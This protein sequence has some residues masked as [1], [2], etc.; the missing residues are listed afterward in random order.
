MNNVEQQF[1]HILKQLLSL[2]DKLEKL[3]KAVDRIQARNTERDREYWER[4]DYQRR[5]PY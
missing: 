4:M 3:A 2:E 1:K 5:G